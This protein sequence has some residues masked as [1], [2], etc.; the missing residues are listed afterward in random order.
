VGF[1]GVY[2]FV[3]VVSF[4][5]V[6]TTV[7]WVLLVYT[8]TIGTAEGSVWEDWMEEVVVDR[9][10]LAGSPAASVELETIGIVLEARL[11]NRRD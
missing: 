1:T 10:L 3:Y 5:E 7:V 4:V 9:G 8:Y 11:R 6:V 2:A